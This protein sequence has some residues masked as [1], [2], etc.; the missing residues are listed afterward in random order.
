MP[1]FT[2]PVRRFNRST[3]PWDPKA[4]PMAYWKGVGKGVN[5]YVRPD[6]SVVENTDPGN[7]IY[8]YLGG[9]IYSVSDAEAA[10]LVAAGYTLDYS[11]ASYGSGAYGDGAYGG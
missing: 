1:L 10:I 8:T 2:P 5:V 7:A 3:Y 9:H 11:V 4:R 6:N